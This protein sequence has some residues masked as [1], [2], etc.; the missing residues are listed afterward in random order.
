MS[1]TGSLRPWRRLGQG[2]R[3]LGHGLPGLALIALAAFAFLPDADAATGLTLEDQA[4]AGAA[5]VGGVPLQL[6]GA[7][8]RAAFIYKVYLAGLY[9]PAKA[10]T[11]AEVL[12]EPGPKRLQLRL[13]MDGSADELAGALA[14][15]LARR[16]SAASA[17][18]LRDRIA[19]FDRLLRGVG[20]VHKGDVVDLDFVPAV[21]LTLALNGRPVG[22]AL[23][24]AD[25]CL[26][27]LDLFVGER[28]ADPR[29][30]TGLLGA[31]S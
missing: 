18:A 5:R 10:A 9:L 20:H 26:A 22:A 4:F 24:G 7:G 31:A 23:P 17:P 28:A 21:G 6:N 2:L 27:L 25:L 29:L 13:L 8:V 19:A 3:A 30:K 16:T 15:P 14:G 12:A 11:G 1:R